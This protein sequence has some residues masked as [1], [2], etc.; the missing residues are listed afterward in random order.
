MLNEALI[1]RPPTD[2]A[3][4]QPQAALADLI[5]AEA[6]SWLNTPWEHQGRIKGQAVDCANF[7]AMTFAAVL[8]Q[9][10]AKLEG[11]KNNY[12]RNENGK[13]L[14]EILRNETDFVET[15]DRQRGDLIAFIDEARK[16]RDV[17][18]HLVFIR[19]VTNATTI[20]IDPTPRGVR[21]HRLNAYWVDRIHSVW[22]VKQQ[23]C[24]EVRQ[25]S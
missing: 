25:Q 7:I 22:R 1:V 6:E 23:Y 16:E 13:L 8:P 2:L 3:V 19:N 11:L 17:P 21:R 9:Y 4:V 5:V 20:V 15:E 12:R 14:R 10:H 24:D 18:R